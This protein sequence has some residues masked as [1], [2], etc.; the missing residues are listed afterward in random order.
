M[1]QRTLVAPIGIERGK[2]FDP[3]GKWFRLSAPAGA[4]WDKSFVLPEVERVV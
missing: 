4:F 3:Q 2:P 1:R